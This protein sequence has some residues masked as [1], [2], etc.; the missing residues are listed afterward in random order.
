MKAVLLTL[1]VV[2][3]VLA[4]NV[5]PQGVFTHNKSINSVDDA[6]RWVSSNIAY[7]PDNVLNDW[8]L[9]RYTYESRCG[10]CE[11]FVLLFMYFL[12]EM[13][14]SSEAVVVECYD[15]SFHAIARVGVDYYEVVGGVWAI[16]DRRLYLFY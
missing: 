15:G 5:E 4:C 8:A 2:A 6:L 3:L 13:G 1:L 12:D 16:S 14:I 10:D 7:T 9:P 11:D